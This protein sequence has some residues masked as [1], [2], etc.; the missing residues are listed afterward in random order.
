MKQ[1]Y[2]AFFFFCNSYVNQQLSQTIT[3]AIYKIVLFCM[4]FFNNNKLRYINIFVNFYNMSFVSFI[5]TINLFL[6][7]ILWKIWKTNYSSNQWMCMFINKKKLLFL[8]ILCGASKQSLW[9]LNSD[10]LQRLTK[11]RQDI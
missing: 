8:V 2:P 11:H 5:L 3:W 9:C 1:R 7:S 6:I 4:I 10:I